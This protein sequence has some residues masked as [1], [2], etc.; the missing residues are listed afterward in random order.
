MGT[1]YSLHPLCIS[2]RLLCTKEQKREA[3]LW[4]TCLL[5]TPTSSKASERLM[6][7]AYV[8]GTSG[9][10]GPTEMEAV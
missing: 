4:T 10:Q 7:A 6:S 1:R 9:L 8:S 3:W 2:Q 5:L